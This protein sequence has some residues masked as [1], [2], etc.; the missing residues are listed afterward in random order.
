MDLIILFRLMII[1]GYAHTC[2]F[3]VRPP[4]NVQ[5]SILVVAGILIVP[6][7]LG[8]IVMNLKKVYEAIQTIAAVYSY[9][10]QVNLGNLSK[11][12]ENV[13]KG[14]TINKSNEDRK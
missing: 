6:G 3:V 7:F 4:E 14:A 8:L 2:V 10:N 13:V 5:L 9:W 11:E 1:F 12:A